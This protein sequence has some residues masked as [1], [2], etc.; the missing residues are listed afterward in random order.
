MLHATV[1]LA[2][3]DAGPAAFDERKQEWDGDK[4]G[5]PVSAVPHQ[6]AKRVRSSW[7]ILP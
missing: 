6:S 3:V 2:V 5:A 4:S 1:L 7:M